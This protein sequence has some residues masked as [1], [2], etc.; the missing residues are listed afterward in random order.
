MQDDF[1][2]GTRSRYL[3]A[4]LWFALALFCLALAFGMLSAPIQGHPVLAVLIKGSI[5]LLLGSI[6]VGTLVSGI[7]TLSGASGKARG[8]PDEALAHCLTCGERTPNDVVCPVCGEPPCDRTRSFH[9]DKQGWGGATFGVALFGALFCLGLFI[10]IGPYYDGERRVWVLLACGGLALLLLAVGGA[11][12][13]GSLGTLRKGLGGGS[14][15]SYSVGGKERHAGGSGAALW[16]KLVWLSGQAR[17]VAPLSP[18]PANEGGYRVSAGDIEFA[19]MVATLN[20]AGIVI[21]E[22]VTTY[23]FRLGEEPAKEGA[24]PRARG[25]GPLPFTRTKNR[26]LRIR[27]APIARSVTPSG[28]YDDGLSDVLVLDQLLAAE[29]RNAVHRFFA[30]YLIE[31]TDVRQLRH[32]LDENPVHRAQAITHAHALREGGIGV[33][34]ELVDAVLGGLREAPQPPST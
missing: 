13:V 27:L 25:N 7:N 1:D 33:A 5:V 9:V 22:D 8:V 26:C 2:L 24:R 11:G 21:L 32:R 14:T 30:Q 10:L 12:L 34:Q 6:G 16:G 31:E 23:H 28:E 3:G 20:A 19:E 17:V 4:I 29:P 15:L 18:Y